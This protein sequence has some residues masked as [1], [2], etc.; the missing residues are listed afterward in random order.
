MA[1][2]GHRRP[3]A[4]VGRAGDDRQ[5]RPAVGAVEE[6]IADNAGRPGSNS[7]ARQSAQ[8]ATSGEMK[9]APPVVAR[10]GLDAELAIAACRPLPRTKMFDPGQR[11]RVIGEF[12]KET[13]AAPRLPPRPR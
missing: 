1:N 4:V 7:S 13:V 3:R 6:G 8:V 5:P 2:A 12:T 9:I 11:R 10:A